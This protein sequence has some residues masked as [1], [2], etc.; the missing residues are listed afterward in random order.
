MATLYFDESVL[1]DDEREVFNALR[2]KCEIDENKEK[3]IRVS[4]AMTR[5]LAEKR[6]NKLG[7][8]KV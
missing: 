6:E 1:S 2:E 4:E 3:E 8:K 5:I 7:G